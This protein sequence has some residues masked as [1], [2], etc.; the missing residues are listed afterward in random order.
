MGKPV[1]GSFP[2]PS[3]GQ[4]QRHTV[5]V[6]RYFVVI[7]E[8]GWG[9]VTR[10]LCASLGNGVY[11]RFKPRG[12]HEEALGGGRGAGWVGEGRVPQGNGATLPG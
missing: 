1:F 3:R 4:R 12:H 10:W 5:N 11:P 9:G 7:W 2:S 6:P 8:M